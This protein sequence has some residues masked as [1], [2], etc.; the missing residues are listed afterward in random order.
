[1]NT[2][3]NPFGARS[4][5]ATPLGAVDV[6]RLDALSK[7]GVAGVDRLP[8]SMRVILE[9]ALRNMDG[10]TVTEEDVLGLARW[11]A[12]APKAV[13]VP[14][15]P[16]RVVLQDF[17]G[18]PCIVDLAAMRDAM[19]RLGGDPTKINPLVPVDLVIDHSVQ[20]DAFGSADALAK[21]V[22]IEFARNGERYR[23]LKWGQKSF[24]QFRAVPP[25]TG[26][27]HQV[28]LEYLAS[29]VATRS[30]GGRTI[31]LPDSVVGT[32]SHTTMINGLGVVGWGVG[33]IEAEA[34]M[35]GQP[36]Y[37]LTPR[38]VGMKLVGRAARGRDRHRPRADRDAGAAQEGRRRP[39]RRVLR[40]RAS[41]ALSLR[42]PRDGRQHGARVRRDDGVLPRR[43][44]DARVPAAH[45]AATSE[46]SGS[47]SDT[48]RSRGSSAPTPRPS[49]TFTDTV[50]LDL[51][52][53]EPC[54]AGPKRPQDRVAL[55][56]V[57]DGFRKALPVPLAERGFGLDAAAAAKTGLMPSV[58]VGASKGGGG[59]DAR[60]DEGRRTASS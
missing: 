16:A 2:P 60:G 36:I 38:V 34:V 49:P 26:I 5:L 23:F 31:A 11:S 10:F 18:V 28:N 37:M 9:A 4:S 56:K 24:R 19:K 32:D 17:T 35:L 15:S 40:R 27:V 55:S 21:N 3:S 13:E 52:S 50:E 46:Q 47:S 43:R 58:R 51:A 30:V 7:A 12:K 54:L 53:I 48:R 6:F 33:G 45:R 42:R 29:V 25:A 57:K 22:E 8:Y 41:S 1:M 59:R 20:V 44:R 39:V 14:F